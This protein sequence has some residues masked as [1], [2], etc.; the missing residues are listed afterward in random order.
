MFN[1]FDPR[2]LEAVAQKVARMRRR[3]PHLS[4]REL[5]ER[6]VAEKCWWC[7]LAGALTAVPAVVPGAGTVVA[8]LGGAAVDV[9]FLTHLLSGLVLELAAVYGRP[10]AGPG[11]VRESLWA[12]MVATG[13]GGLGAGLSRSA[14]AHLSHE[15]Y[16]NLLHRVLWS[17]GLRS[18]GRSTLARLIPVF[19]IA[20]AGGVN[21]AVARAVGRR[22][23]AYYESRSPEGETTVEGEYRVLD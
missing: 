22:A 8:L 17:L 15:A 23:L 3:E 7:A 21:Y 6:V 9:F 11:P 16:A 4:R 18:V 19:G 20:L 12:F 10:L 2:R 1:P 5:A 13:A 14:V